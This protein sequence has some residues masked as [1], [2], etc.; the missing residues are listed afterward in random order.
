L[1]HEHFDQLQY[2]RPVYLS[3]DDSLGLARG[4]S[5][6]M[7]MLNFPFPY[8][9]PE[10]GRRFA[11]MRAA[12]DSALHVRSPAAL[13]PA[14]SAY[15]DAKKQLRALLSADEDKYLG[16]QL[17]Q[18]GIARYTEVRMAS[19]A[20]EEGY[21]ASPAFRALPDYRSYQ[22]Q[23]TRAM[24]RIDRELAIPMEDAQRTAFYPIGAAEGLVL[25]RVAPT[26]R[27]GYFDHM[28]RI[29]PASNPR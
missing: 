19:L 2:S 18:E 4:D 26:W 14:W 29:G 16:F 11:V 23:A 28:F 15:L 8:A 22:E 9:K 3:K 12:L 24:S 6:G 21:V 7:W 10:I 27:A 13:T 1:L 20:A 17:W 5:T 25:D